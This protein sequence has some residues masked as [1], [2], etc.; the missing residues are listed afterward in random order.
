MGPA[1]DNFRLLCLALLAIAA[2]G[3]VGVARADREDEVFLDGL[4]Q[5]RLFSLAETFCR[6]RLAEP[7]LGEAERAE[8][9][10]ELAQTKAQHALNTAP[11]DR[12][13]L[14][15]EA[16]QVAAVGRRR[17]LR[18][19]FPRT[20]RAARAHGAVFARAARE[21]AHADRRRG[22]SLLPR[23]RAG[24]G[25]GRAAR[26][27]HLGAVGALAQGGNTAAH[28]RRL[29]RQATPVRRRDRHAQRRPA[30]AAERQ[31]QGAHSDLRVLAPN[32]IHAGMAIDA[33]MRDQPIMCLLTCSGWHAVK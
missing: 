28:R 27:S 10:I 30:G 2:A 15:Q 13:P 18:R 23:R 3:P 32:R 9:V 8:L 25:E 31:T 14:W 5:R 22:F 19:R 24:G 21:S 33:Q 6:E 11:A 26:R 4:R 17:A 16:R 20:H 1:T 7:D 12:G 29:L